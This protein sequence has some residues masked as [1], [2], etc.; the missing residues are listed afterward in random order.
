MQFKFKI[1]KNRRNVELG[2]DIRVGTIILI[3][4]VIIL[5]VCP[6]KVDYLLRFLGLYNSIVG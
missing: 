4:F 1:I 5:F 3:V 2:I 6:D